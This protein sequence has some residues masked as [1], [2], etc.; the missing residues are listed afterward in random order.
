MCLAV[1]SHYE[2]GRDVYDNASTEMLMST[3]VD[4]DEHP[5][6]V[7]A[8][9]D[10]HDMVF[11]VVPT[12]GPYKG[13]ILRAAWWGA[14][15][16]EYPSPPLRK[17]PATCAV[18]EEEEAAREGMYERAAFGAFMAQASEASGRGGGAALADVGMVAQ[19]GCGTD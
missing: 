10:E 9:E 14:Y 4:M 3:G 7:R 19:G 16:R 11:Y 15:R 1:I 12:F 2:R 17:A 13:R 8:L 5:E 6:M 18:E